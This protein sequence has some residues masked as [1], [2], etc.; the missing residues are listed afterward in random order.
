MT[1]ADLATGDA[2]FVDANTLIHFFQPHP[3]WGQF[4]HQ[5]IQRIDNQDTE[6]VRPATGPADRPRPPRRQRFPRR[7][8]GEHKRGGRD[9]DDYF[10]GHCR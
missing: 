9:T 4:C 7:H 8:G 10:D 5:L 6:I 1:F 2:V 3:Q